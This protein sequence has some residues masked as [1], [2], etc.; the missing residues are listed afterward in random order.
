MPARLDLIGRNPI[1]S[2]QEVE[3]RDTLERYF[4]IAGTKTRTIA[5][6]RSLAYSSNPTYLACRDRF[7]EGLRKAG[8]P[9]E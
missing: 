9:E 5:R 4:L 8:M 6:W 3:A 1:L 7:Y 2:G